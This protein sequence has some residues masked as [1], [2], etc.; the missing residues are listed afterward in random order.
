MYL[1]KQFISSAANDVYMHTAQR[2]T[3][4]DR[5]RDRE[6]GRER[7]RERETDSQ[8]ERNKVGER[9]TSLQTGK[10]KLYTATRK[11]NILSTCI[12]NQK[13]QPALP[14]QTLL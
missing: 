3:E 10:H 1:V 6:T 7:V 4:R 11:V 8:P 12:Q 2:K 13:R 9:H 14:F 5:Q